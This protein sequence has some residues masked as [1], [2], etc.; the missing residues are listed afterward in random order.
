M[1]SK[2]PVHLK[3][4]SADAL[5]KHVI[6]YLRNRATELDTLARTS[7]D[8]IERQTLMRIKHELQAVVNHYN[9]IVIT[10]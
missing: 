4:I 10:N 8:P 1:Q 3:N 9:N 5:R 7:G 2:K 6:A